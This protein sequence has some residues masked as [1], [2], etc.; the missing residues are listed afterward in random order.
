MDPAISAGSVLHI[1]AG[2]LY[3][4]VA[5]CLQKCIYCDFY[6]IGVRR[7]DWKGYVDALIAELHH[8]IA[9]LP[10]PLRTIYIGGGTPSLIP[11]KDFIRLCKT[12]Y[13]YSGNVEEF[14]IEV[15]PDDVTPDMLDVWKRGG[16][17][18]LSMGIQSF[19]DCILKLIKRRHTAATAER[20]YTMAREVFDNISIDLIYGIPGQNVNMW[21]KDISKAVSMHPKHIS[22]YS[23][24]Y[25]EGTALTLLR[26]KGVLSEVTEETSE[27]MMN[28]LISEL[29]KAG[30]EHYEISNFA[31]PGFR[32]RHN[33]SY[34]QSTPYLGLGPSAHS[35]DG[36]RCRSANKADVRAYINYW[37]AE[38]SCSESNIIQREF[39]SEEE[40]REEYVMT[41]LRT[42]E[43][44]DLEDF[45]CR[46]GA[47]EYKKLLEKSDIYIKGKSLIASDSHLFLSEKAFLISDSIIVAL[48]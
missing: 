27:T 10:C 18:R 8:R 47:I 15:N 9:E 21:R 32:S 6:S 45:R 37:N 11:P 14:T 46:F 17:N 2:G 12:I 44:I 41:R 16:I 33:S 28:I 34:W 23:L 40:L 13:S 22:S 43:G 30:Y 5:Y 42:K 1:A 38:G 24:M 48:A 4:H 39:L 25:E 29:R 3:V 36:Q 20:A 7:A 19:D 31:M 26:D 35:Y